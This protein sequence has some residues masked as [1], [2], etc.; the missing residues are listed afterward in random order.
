MEKPATELETKY[1]KLAAEYSKVIIPTNLNEAIIKGVFSGQ[2]SSWG[3]KK[4]RTG[5]AG[6]NQRAE[7]GYQESR[8]N[9]EET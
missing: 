3:T 5:R 4:G 9:I 6:Q 8:A 2:I 7:G 1:Q